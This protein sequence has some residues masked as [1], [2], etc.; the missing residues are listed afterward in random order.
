M[1]E[2]RSRDKEKLKNL[3]QKLDESLDGSHNYAGFFPHSDRKGL[4]GY[5]L[6]FYGSYL[7]PRT[8]Q[9]IKKHDLE[10]ESMSIDPWE[11][12]DNVQFKVLV[13][14]RNRDIKEV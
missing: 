5:D 7:F 12:K 6:Y 14:E 11:Y 8:K 4:I 2:N 13:T 10:I 3:V 9:E 1:N